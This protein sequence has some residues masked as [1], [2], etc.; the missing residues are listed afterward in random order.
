LIIITVI[1]SHR[2]LSAAEANVYR[3]Y[4]PPIDEVNCHLQEL[5]L[6]SFFGSIAEFAFLYK[7]LHLFF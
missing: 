3:S 2:W 7:K 1:F 5:K 6:L 4:K